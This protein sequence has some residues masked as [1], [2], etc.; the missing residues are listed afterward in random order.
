MTSCNHHPTFKIKM[1][2]ART[3]VYICKNCGAE[4]EMTAQTKMISKIINALTIGVLVYLALNGNFTKTQ[5]S[6]NSTLL[7]FA[8]MAGI[9]VAYLLLQAL[10]MTFG[11]FDE[12]ESD[13]TISETSA[14]TDASDTAGTSDTDDAGSD[15]QSGTDSAAPGSQYTQ[16]QLEL[17]ALYESYAKLDREENGENPGNTDMPAEEVP[18]PVEDTCE[19]VPAKNWKNYVPGVYD[20]K[21]DKC[22]KVITFSVAR[23]KR[24]N[25]ILLAFSTIILMASF[26]T[27]SIPFWGLGLM[28]VGVVILCSFVQYFFVKN[29][30]FEI[31]K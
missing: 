30:V 15:R 6:T 21:C 20:F 24:L 7:Y 14:T 9:V 23:K 12:I 18:V 3:T 16:E 13:Q 5:T 28:A 31:K 26:S 19:H 8:A 17:M 22:G 29:S 4:L 27:Q 25:L 2:F 11:K 10:L 1:L